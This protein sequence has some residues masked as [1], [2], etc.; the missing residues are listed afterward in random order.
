M[1]RTLANILKVVGGGEE[2]GVLIL[3]M[4]VFIRMITSQSRD[5]L[6]TRQEIGRED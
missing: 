3:L 5:S 6:Q 4:K 1:R 2:E